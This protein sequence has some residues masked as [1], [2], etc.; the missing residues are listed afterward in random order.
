MDDDLKAYFSKR[1]EI[2]PQK[3]E[4][5]HAA[6]NAAAEKSPP[7]WVVTPFVML[8]SLVF[9]F[10]LGFMLGHGTV[11]LLGL[12]YYSVTALTVAAV[13]ILINKEDS[14]CLQ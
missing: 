11:L 3:R 8:F 5:L 4:A 7:I 10:M 2:S 12:I 1:D 9:M 13:I 14:V 6:L